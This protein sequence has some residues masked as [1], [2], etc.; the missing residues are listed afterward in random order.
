MTRMDN[1]KLDPAWHLMPAD[2]LERVFNQQECDI[3]QEFLGFTNV[4]LALAT[5]IPKHWTVIDL[6]CAYAPQAMIFKDHVRYLGID[7]GGKER[8]HAPNTEHFDMTIATFISR[9]IHDFDQ[10]TTFAICSYVPPWHNDNV[11]L[12]RSSFKNVFTYYPSGGHN[13]FPPSIKGTA[14]KP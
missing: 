10:N 9:H 3:D 7:Y 4:Y 1:T 6:G 12:A 11:D 5:I 14:Q 2:Q 13:Y 8:F